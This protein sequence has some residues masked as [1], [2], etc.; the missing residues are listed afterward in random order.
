MIC[1]ECQ[2]FISDYIDGLLE[3]GEQV[4]IERHLADCEPCRAVRDDLLQI[5]HFSH[6]LP[7][8]APSG[9][10]WAR[11]QSDIAEERPA[12]FVAR[13]GAWWAQLKTRN[14]N[15][16][17]PQMVAS[18]AALAIIISVGVLITGRNVA[19]DQNTV[20]S[21]TEVNAHNLQRL[22]NPD[23][24]QLEQDVS[25]L[26]ETIEQRKST[27]NPEL[28]AAFDRNMYYVNQSLAECRHQLNDNPSDDVS[29]ELMLNAYREKVRLLEGFQSF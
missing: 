25:R 7:E 28:R 9:A 15:L 10:L 21:V 11:I 26:S 12:G 1:K 17:I 27:W 19:H 4:K 14:F 6:Q 16:S 2:E 13:A 5:V 20:A 23:I 8:H 3:L 24:Q 18:A 22:S 29:Q